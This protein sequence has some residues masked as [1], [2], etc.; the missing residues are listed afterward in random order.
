MVSRLFVLIGDFYT[1]EKYDWTFEIWMDFWNLIEL[2]NILG[3]ESSK[4]ISAEKIK[5]KNLNQ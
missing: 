1:D 2:P 3:G 4:W 5:I